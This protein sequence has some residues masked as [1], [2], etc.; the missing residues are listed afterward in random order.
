[1]NKDSRRRGYQGVL[2]GQELDKR[3]LGTAFA[4]SE[5]GAQ[6]AKHLESLDEIAAGKRQSRHSREVT[7]SNTQADNTL[8]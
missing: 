7:P 1:M 6:E 2:F 4:V 5:P 8:S 3:D